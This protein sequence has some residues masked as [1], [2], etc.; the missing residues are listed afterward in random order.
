MTSE[1]VLVWFMRLTAAVM[2]LAFGGAVMP[3]SWMEICHR[4]M[5]L[6][7]MPSAPI[8]KYLA[9]STSALYGYIGVLFLVLSR[10]VRR[11]LPLI[12][13]QGWMCVASVIPL[14]ILD[15]S[16]GMPDSWTMG[17]V[18]SPLIQG[19]VILWLVARVR[20]AQAAE[21]AKIGST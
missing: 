9:R 10:D 19:V 4:A 6:G 8:V 1:R 3:F 20:K 18:P 7:D 11:Y 14:Y 16:S 2:L 15:T 12:G 5:G 21:D 13:L 17:E